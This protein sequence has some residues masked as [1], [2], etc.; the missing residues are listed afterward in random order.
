MYAA[1]IR[2][3]RS[4]K[5]LRVSI[6]RYFRQR[7]GKVRGIIRSGKTSKNRS[8]V[9]RHSAHTVMLPVCFKDNCDKHN[10]G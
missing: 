4:L 3:T 8:V 9:F 10:H 2:L 5:Y 1:I 6:G 7:Y